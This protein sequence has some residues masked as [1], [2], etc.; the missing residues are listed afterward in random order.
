MIKVSFAA[1]RYPRWGGKEGIDIEREE[2]LRCEQMDW[3]K[4]KIEHG[5]EH[6]TGRA[7]LCKKKKRANIIFPLPQLP[8]REKKEKAKKQKKNTKKT[9]KKPPKNKQTNKSPKVANI[10][11]STNLPEERLTYSSHQK[12][13]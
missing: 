10:Y 12:L 5:L 7:L 1:L 3:N 9:Q 13:K 4:S 6:V 8:S 2:Q 11:N